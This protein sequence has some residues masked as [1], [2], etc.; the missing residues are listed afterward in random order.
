[1]SDAE[2]PDPQF[3]LLLALDALEERFRADFELDVEFERMPDDPPEKDPNA[4]RFENSI[5]AKLL[6]VADSLVASPQLYQWREQ[7]NGTFPLRDLARVFA[8]FRLVRPQLQID[9]ARRDLSDLDKK[10]ARLVHVLSVVIEGQ[11]P[12]R[13]RAYLQRVAR[14]YVAGLD[15]ETV[16]M[17]RAVLD[18]AFEERVP[19]AALESHLKARSLTRAPVLADRITVAG[20]TGII[21]RDVEAAA[22]RVKDAGNDAVHNAPGANMPALEAL[23]ETTRI[24][25]ALA[26]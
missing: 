8:D 3:S 21:S 15:A 11:P 17:C 14:C 19:E 4:A 6:E 18:A 25:A 9:L 24:L 20:R 7:L 12:E 13:V 22:R 23:T 10:A 1:M 16:V 26:I 2:V 5:A